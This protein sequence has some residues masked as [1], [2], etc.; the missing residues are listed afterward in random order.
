MHINKIVSCNSIINPTEA[1]DKI[2]RGI[3]FLANCT[4]QTLGP[5]GRNF[6]IE[7]GLKITNDGI[8]IAKEIQ[9]KDEIEDLGLRVARNAAVKTNDEVG[10]GTTT[11]L[12]LVQAILKEIV[13]LLP[14]KQLAGR[15][16]VI[17]I[18]KQIAKERKE[19][20]EKLKE[21]A[22]PIKTKEELIDVA[23]VAVEDR[24]LAELIGS[25]QWELGPEGTLIVEPT[26]DLNDSVEKINGIRFDNGFGTSLMM[27]NKEK[28]RLEVKN[29]QVIMTNYTFHD[30]NP[31]KSLLDQM[32]KNNMKNIV[33]V[34]R[35][36]TDE[37][38]QICMK[39]HEVGV[40]I[41]PINAPYVNQ[42]EVMRD[43]QAVLGGTYFNQEE[44]TLEEMQVSDLGFAEEVWSYR[45][46]A[47][48]TGVKDERADERI[49][50]RVI[51]LRKSLKGEES[52]FMK[53]EIETRISQLTNG[54]S[55]I[56]IGAL[57][58]E[59]RKYKLD[60][61]EDGVNTVKS[62]LEEGTVKGAGL[63]FKEISDGMTDDYIL[64]R[65]L[66]SIN[67]Q[68][69]SNAGEIFEIEPWVKDSVKVVRVAFEN[70]CEIAANLATA[71][72]AVAAERPKSRYVEEVRE[73]ELE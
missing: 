64:K 41:Y 59:E 35:A 1:T 52:V 7:K 42:G 46:S 68:I 44:R 11:S 33:I 6:L 28:Q 32:V 18:R 24:E 19:V 15:K 10:D 47:I 23:R 39:N 4:K 27:N 61:A 36:F 34:A 22:T 14:G 48:F 26:N 53:K 72:G 63:A 2:M 51:D 65:P 73:E 29:V 71:C 50:N 30:L 37:A 25:T 12:V 70:A 49:K 40:K 16:S 5:W 69:F 55:L 66:L 17:E 60:K 21:F 45:F 67:Q 62:A 8:S 20:V 13:K 38:I 9:L 31:V 58:D 3:D 43:L 54:F 56:K 57:S